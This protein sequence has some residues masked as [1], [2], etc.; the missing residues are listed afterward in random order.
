M[1]LSYD[2][3]HEKEDF[4]EKV[5]ASR[6]VFGRL[7]SWNFDKKNCINNRSA[8]GGEVGLFIIDEER[9]DGFITFFIE[10]FQRYPKPICRLS[11]LHSD[12]RASPNAYQ[13][14]PCCDSFDPSKVLFLAF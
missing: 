2:S 5:H 1:M 3:F 4:D 14:S 10:Q 7:G 12:P 11:I 9:R 6:Q 8:T 13:D